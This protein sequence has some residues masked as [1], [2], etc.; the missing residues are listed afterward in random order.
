MVGK[1]LGWSWSLPTT[2][3]RNNKQDDQIISYNSLVGILYNMIP[4]IYVYYNAF[5]NTIK[6][7]DERIYVYISR[8]T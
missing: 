4:V 3:I 1:K 5:L 2:Y 8:T 6:K 7:Q